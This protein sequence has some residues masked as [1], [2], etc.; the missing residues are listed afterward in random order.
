MILTV[1]FYHIFFKETA[2][3]DFHPCTRPIY[4]DLCT[5]FTAVYCFTFYSEIILTLNLYWLKLL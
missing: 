4:T 2:A 5:G 1:L 3:R